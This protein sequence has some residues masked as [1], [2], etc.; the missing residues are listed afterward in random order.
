MQVRTVPDPATTRTIGRD[1]LA[2]TRDR[3][4]IRGLAEQLRVAR[5]RLRT[6]TRAVFAR[7]SE[8]RLAEV[9]STFL[10]V[11]DGS[12]QALVK[13]IRW[14]RTTVADQMSTLSEILRPGVTNQLIFP[15]PRLQNLKLCAHS[16]DASNV[17]G[18]SN[19]VLHIAAPVPD[20]AV[21][22]CLRRIF[23][24]RSLRPVERAFTRQILPYDPVQID[25]VGTRDAHN[26]WIGRD[27]CKGIV[28]LRLGGDNH[29]S[30]PAARVK[31][32]A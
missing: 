8:D 4:C 14:I 30:I 10:G 19:I 9:V 13:D 7:G 2:A 25:V 12:P 20:V 15:H 22:H 11:C 32:E 17:A 5:N 31:Q 21:A 27:G 6:V 29:L 23:R 18:A 1:V 3:I 28:R 16:S 24:V 26:V